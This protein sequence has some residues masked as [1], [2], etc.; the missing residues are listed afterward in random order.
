MADY[1]PLIHAI[2]HYTE[3]VRRTAKDDVL[4]PGIQRLAAAVRKYWK[5]QGAAFLKGLAA[6]EDHF[7]AGTTEALRI[8]EAVTGSWEPIFGAAAT[9]EDMAAL[10]ATVDEELKGALAAGGQAVV[11][12][13][14][15]TKP[16]VVMGPG[17]KDVYDPEESGVFNVGNPRAAAY[18]EAHGA[19]LVTRIDETTRERING[20]ITRGVN[21]GLSYRGIADNIRGLFDNWAEPQEH[22]RDRAEMV[23]LTELHTGYEEG[24][25]NGVLDLVKAGLAIEKKWLTVQDERVCHLCEDNEGDGWISHD[26]DHSSGD[27]H[28][29]AHPS[30]R[31]TEEYRREVAAGGA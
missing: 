28:P 2:D 26:T 10:A 17:G 21:Q 22:V 6:V 12:S 5:R 3:A 1:G 13:L 11:S 31:C 15:P 18:L 4:D 16:G 24:S 8:R 27:P 19:D 23:A 20:L 25:Y 7:P 14:R 29:T 9:A 30:D